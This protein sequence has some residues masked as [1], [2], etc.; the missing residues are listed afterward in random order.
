M[1]SLLNKSEGGKKERFIISRV[2]NEVDVS[3]C[4]PSVDSS[5]SRQS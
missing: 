5:F 4:E 2:G 1:G 3:H